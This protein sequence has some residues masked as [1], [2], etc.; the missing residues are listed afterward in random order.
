[1]DEATFKAL[2]ANKDGQLDATELA[3]WFKQPPDLE[4]MVPLSGPK[5]RSPRPAGPLAWL[6]GAVDEGPLLVV[7]PGRLAPALAAAVQKRDDGTMLLTTEAARVECHKER[8]SDEDLNIFRRFF[9]EQFRA[10]LRDKKT[11]LEKK[12]VARNPRLKGLFSFIDR[13]GDG[14]ATEEE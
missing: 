3:A 10:A 12:D 6:F 8:G 11:Y 2:D 1:F 14:R 13:D 4:L 7:G 9:L 5:P